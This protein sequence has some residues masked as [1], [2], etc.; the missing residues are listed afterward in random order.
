MHIRNINISKNISG[1]LYNSRIVLIFA[2]ENPVYYAE[3]ETI[4][5]FEHPAIFIQIAVVSAFVV[6]PKHSD[7]KFSET[8]LDSANL[9][10]ICHLKINT[11]RF[12][13]INCI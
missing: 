1:Y 9:N 11:F 7:W 5:L 3:E 6:G 4:R 8:Y 10:S 12:K 13:V 2:T